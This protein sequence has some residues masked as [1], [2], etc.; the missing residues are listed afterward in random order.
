MTVVDVHCHVYPAKIA[1]RA[2]ASVGEFYGVPMLDDPAINETGALHGSVDYLQKATAGS[3]ITHS[4]V[5]SVATKANQVQSINNF[6]AEECAKNPS[7]IGFMTM[8]QDFPNPEEEI[9]RAA[10]MGLKGIKIHPD[11]QKVDLDDPRLMK[12]YEIAEAKGLPLIIHTGDYR[13]DYSHPRRMQKVLHDF[14][15][16]VVNAAHFGGWSIYDLAIEYMEHENCFLDVSSA[17]TYLGRRRTRELIDIYGA[18]RILFG[19]D[20]PMWSPSGELATV[21]SLGLSALEYEKITWRNAERFIGIDI[22]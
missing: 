5:H 16:L 7:F 8:H 22:L 15:N 12:V 18:D 19:S 11:T 14:P 4:V 21:Q 9:E 20:F 10:G 2:N 1:E 13:Y 6:I 17:M 3:D